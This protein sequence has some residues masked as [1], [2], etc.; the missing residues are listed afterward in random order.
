MQ[1]YLC[2]PRVYEY[3]GW[4]FEVPAACG[5]WPLKKDGDLRKRAGNVFYTMFE[6]FNKLSKEEKQMY[7][8]GGGCV[9]F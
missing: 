9:T 4:I 1:G 3:N 8:V 6:K 2:G 5:P 7:R